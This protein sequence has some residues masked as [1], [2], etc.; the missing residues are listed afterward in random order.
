MEQLSGHAFDAS[1]LISPRANTIPFHRETVLKRLGMKPENADEYLFKL[2]D[3]LH[4]ECLDM[5]HPSIGYRTLA[6]P[7]F[8]PEKNQITLEDQIF[9]TGEIVTSMLKD[10]EF[11]VIFACTPGKEV[12]QFSKEQLKKNNPL[13]G[14]LIDLI[15]SELADGLAEFIHDFIEQKAA[16]KGLGVTDRFSPGYCNW[17]VSAQHHLFSLLKDYDCGIKLTDSSLMIPI[18]SISGIFGIGQGLHKAGYKCRHC[19]DKN[20]ILRMPR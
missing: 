18:K 12:E 19:S 11:I 5:V 9:D 2:L 14:Y 3:K 1:G 8:N 16:H 10:S 4:G 6:H 7:G 20:C 13:E 17:N 15:G